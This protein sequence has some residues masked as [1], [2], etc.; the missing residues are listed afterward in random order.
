MRLRHRAS[1]SRSARN[2]RRPPATRAP[3]SPAELTEFLATDVVD[4][5][6]SV[7]P[8]QDLAP[9]AAPLEHEEVADLLGS[10]LVECALR[11]RAQAR[12]IAGL[13]RELV[14]VPVLFLALPR[15]H[16]CVI[17]GP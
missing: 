14:E 6:W 5:T 10:C 17:E 12:V 1:R 3:A 16:V 13:D 4:F 2:Q 8:V 7:G 11:R 15:H 9:L